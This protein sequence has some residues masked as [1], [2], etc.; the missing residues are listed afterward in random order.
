MLAHH[1]SSLPTALQELYPDHVWQQWKFN[2][3]PKLW[4]H[5]LANQ[6]R[7]LDDLAPKLGVTKMDDWYHI[8]AATL[9]QNGAFTLINKQYRTSSTFWNVSSAHADILITRR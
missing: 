9:R 1:N 5:D 4:W 7:F 2:Q 3:V 8:S 6:K